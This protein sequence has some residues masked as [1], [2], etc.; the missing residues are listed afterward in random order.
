MSH[1]WGK[2]EKGKALG[3]FDGEHLQLI[4]SATL[5]CLHPWKHVCMY[6]MKKLLLNSRDV[7]RLPEVD[8]GAALPVGRSD[9]ANVDE[10]RH[11]VAL[12][13]HHLVVVM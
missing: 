11:S 9:A 4:I 3:R 7:V 8:N 2:C 6:R 5:T 13:V 1:V 10:A 12:P